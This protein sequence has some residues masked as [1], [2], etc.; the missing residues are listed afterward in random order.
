M[1]SCGVERHT[2]FRDGKR[3]T[4][5]EPSCLICAW[6]DYRPYIC[7]HIVI[8][9]GR[10][11]LCVLV[12]GCLLINA[13]HQLVHLLEPHRPLQCAS[14]AAKETLT[15][16]FFCFPSASLPGLRRTSRTH[17]FVNVS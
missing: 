17:V 16:F 5:S 11:S 13:G 14:S 7:T 8:R 15:V 9:T 4:L 10:P 2:P 6:T 3:L 1:L 12:D